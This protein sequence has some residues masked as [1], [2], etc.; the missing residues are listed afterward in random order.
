MLTN[1]IVVSKGSVIGTSTLNKKSIAYSG[2]P[3]RLS[4]NSKYIPVL[5]IVSQKKEGASID[6][7]NKLFM[8]HLDN[9]YMEELYN[10]NCIDQL[11]TYIY[12]TYEDIDYFVDRQYLRSKRSSL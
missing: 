2:R 12:A 8:P 10:N 1:P 7:G 4:T 9:K 6:K 5:R 11:C 3:Y